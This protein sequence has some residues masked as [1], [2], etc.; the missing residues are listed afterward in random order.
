MKTKSRVRAGVLTSNHNETLVRESVKAK[1]LKGK[2]HIKA[3]VLQR[4]SFGC[5]TISSMGKPPVSILTRD[6]RERFGDGLLQGLQC[7]CGLR[8]QERLDLGPTFFDRG[9]VGRIRR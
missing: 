6:R 1:G 2:I 8:S 7:S 9:Q 5:N 4:Y 3:G